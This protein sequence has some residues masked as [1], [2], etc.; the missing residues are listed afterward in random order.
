MDIQLTQILFQIINFSVVFG[1]LGYL[2][3]KPIL[4]IFDERA[5]RIEEGQKAAEKAIESQENLEQLRK[6]M[7]TELKKERAAVISEAQ[8]EAKKRTQEVMA[9]ARAEAETEAAR[10][11][12]NAEKEKRQLLKDARGE[13]ADAVVAVAQTVIGKS[14]DSKAQAQLIDAQLDAIVKQL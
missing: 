9:K 2:L 6:E 1:G 14:L 8:A 5:K 11:K 3:Y 4:K 7:Q 13:M 10:I 12:E